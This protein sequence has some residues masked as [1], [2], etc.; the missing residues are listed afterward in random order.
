MAT[1]EE[2][3]ITPAAAREG[4]AASAI[5]RRISELEARSGVTLLE[6][7]ERGVVPTS[8]G[9][10]LADQLSAVFDLLDTLAFDL[11]AIR[12]GRIGNV[13]IHAHMSAGSGGLADLLASYLVANPGIELEIEELTSLEVMHSV[14]TGMADLGLVSGT[15][16]AGDLEMIPWKEDQLMAL[17]PA[18]HRLAGRS[19]LKLSDLLDD[20]FIGMQRDS[21]LIQLYRH[22]AKALGKPLRERA[23]ATSFE[24]VRKMVSVGL[25]VTILPGT[26]ARVQAGE[27]GLRVVSLEES[28]ATRPLML[29]VRNSK[30]LSRATKG[31]IAHL[32]ALATTV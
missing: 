1:V 10:K 2:G 9:R 11:D 31:V 27:L 28:W 17:L 30:Q 26:A 29:C 19:S 7:H 14:Q 22:Q 3:G 4:I 8:A 13:R 18:D 21:A 20:Y 15:L 16:P 23:H 12:G 6:R 25:G 32:I 24:S 5:S